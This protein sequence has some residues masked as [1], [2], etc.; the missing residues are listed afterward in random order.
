M[1]MAALLAKTIAFNFS[2]SE[3]RGAN[4]GSWFVLERYMVPSLFVNTS[5]QTEYS[6]TKSLGKSRS[7]EL[8]EHHWDTWIQEDDFKKMHNWGINVVRIPVGY[9]AFLEK[10]GDP[11]VQGQLPY[12]D[13]AL[14]WAGKYNIHAMIDL[15]IPP[16]GVANWNDLDIPGTPWIENSTTMDETAEI[17][18]QIAERYD[19]PEWNGVVAAVELLNEP[20]S[21]DYFATNLPFSQAYRITEAEYDKRLYEFYAYLVSN[22]PTS[23]TPVINDFF[24]TPKY[25]W[26]A[27]DSRVAVDYHYY[28]TSLNS[29]PGPISQAV[30]GV[31]SGQM[32]FTNDTRPH[33][34]GEW[35]ASRSQCDTINSTPVL[36]ELFNQ[37][38]YCRGVDDI[39]DWSDQR[40]DD[41][42]RYVEAQLDKFE[43]TG[44]GWIFWSYKTESTIEW[45]LR[46]LIE[47][48][49]FPQPFSHRKFAHQCQK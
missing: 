36:R 4:L 17:L 44:H 1:A 49:M 16:G 30:E 26:F 48:D 14:K 32:D 11:F 22:L 43:Q 6:L 27:N 23:I 46:R 47:Y 24:L 13:R 15:H 7:Q 2:L 3:I 19:G 28:Q 31:C 10:P 40:R 42:R 37:L 8:L 35:S 12:L 38:E 18:L 25:S 20:I 39:S 45:D 34:V 41:M 9:W 29:E 5:G 21:P 33:F